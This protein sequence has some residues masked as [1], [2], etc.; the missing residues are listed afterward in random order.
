MPKRD[1]QAVCCG[2]GSVKALRGPRDLLRR[3][4]PSRIFYRPRPEA[5]S[6]CWLSPCKKEKLL[7]LVA[8]GFSGM[9]L[10][11]RVCRPL[12]ASAV[13]LL[14]P[15]QS[16]GSPARVDCNYCSWYSTTGIAGIII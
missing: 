3:S 5:S 7:G 4:S 16:D 14:L 11:N 10:N 12:V 1:H 15:W 6:S 2:S 8:P 9:K 13:D